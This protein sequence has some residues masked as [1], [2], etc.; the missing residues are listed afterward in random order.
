MWPGREASHTPFSAEVNNEWSYT[1]PSP[2]R[3]NGMDSDVFF[4]NSHLLK[5]IAEL[6]HPLPAILC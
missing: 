2:V 6:L 1:S 3:L 5:S 4:I